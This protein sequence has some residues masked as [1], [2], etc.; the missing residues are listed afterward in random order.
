GPPPRAHQIVYVLTKLTTAM[1][2]GQISWGSHIPRGF[3]KNMSLSISASR[4]G[5]R[6]KREKAKTA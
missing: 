1:D 6:L 4:Y 3:L 5:V 2:V